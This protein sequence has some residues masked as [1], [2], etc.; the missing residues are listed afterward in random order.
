MG[1]FDI[2]TNKGCD[3]RRE[4]VNEIGL[5][6]LVVAAVLLTADCVWLHVKCSRQAEA[7]AALE[8]RVEAHL[9][10]PPTPGVTDKVKETYQKAKSAAVRQYE[11]VKEKFG[12][13]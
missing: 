2:L 7:L 3:M 8:A 1:V 13:K 11:A 4:D 12:G 10:P 5:A 9:N 6:V